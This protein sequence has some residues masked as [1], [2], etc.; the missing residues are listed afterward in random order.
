MVEVDGGRRG[1]D[2]PTAMGWDLELW[3]LGGAAFH[4]LHN[5]TWPDNAPS[6]D[7]INWR[8][9]NSPPSSLAIDS[10]NTEIQLPPALKGRMLHYDLPY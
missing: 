8:A 5:H 4:R 1:R 7:R 2:G 3:W 10:Q 9:Q 6:R